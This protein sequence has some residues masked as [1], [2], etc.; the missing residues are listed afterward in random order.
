MLLLA[1]DYLI[2]LKIQGGCSVPRI[3]LNVEVHDTVIQQVLSTSVPLPLPIM[4]D[5]VDGEILK[6]D[7]QKEDYDADVLFT[8]NL[9]PYFWPCSMHKPLIVLIFLNMAHVSN[10]RGPWVLRGV[11]QAL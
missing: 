6:S 10:Y 11:S 8:I 5:E 1:S 9:G 4:E 7:S 3:D 2:S